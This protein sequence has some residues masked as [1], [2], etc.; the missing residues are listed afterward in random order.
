MRQVDRSALVSHSAQQMYALVADVEAYPQFL[1]W[2]TGARLHEKSASEL[3]ASI[4]IGLGALTTDFSTRNELHPPHSM[5]MELLDGPF[6]R[7]R[8]GWEFESLG[9]AGCEVRLQLQFEFSSS[10]Q[11]VLFG[12]AFEKV[13]KEL[14]DA[15][16]RRAAELYGDD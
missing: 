3:K 2:C 14:I 15:F 12:A 7:L 4:G 6:S 13:C 16:V 8:G 1:P 9:E 10:V 5:T 11:D